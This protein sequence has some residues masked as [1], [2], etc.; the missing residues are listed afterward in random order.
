M[1]STSSR[2]SASSAYTAHLAQAFSLELV[3]LS[4]WFAGKRAAGNRIHKAVFWKL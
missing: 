3:Q 2:V 4:Q 1:M